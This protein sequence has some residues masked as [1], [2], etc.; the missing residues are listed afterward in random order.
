MNVSQTDEK[1][2]VDVGRSARCLEASGIHLGPGT[3]LLLGLRTAIEPPC[4][5]LAGAESPDGFSFGAFSYSW[6]RITRFVGSIGRYCSIAGQVNLGDWEHPT[7]ALTTSVVTF[8]HHFPLGAYARRRNP[9]VF[10][11]RLPSPTPICLENDVWIGKGSYIKSGLAIGTGAIV[12]ANAVVT[13]DVPP[14]AIVAG[15]PAQIKKSRFSD[16]LIDK[17]LKSAWWQYLW[18][19][20]GDIDPIDPSA[21]CDTIAECRRSGHVKRFE[22]KSLNVTQLQAAL[23]GSRASII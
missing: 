19:D 1:I 3:N 18:V 7:D 14:Y 12:G 11:I 2:S 17:L 21:G 13:K 4:S 16:E 10:R 8:D 6:S 20:I 5:I 9:N 23:I 15:V 22:P